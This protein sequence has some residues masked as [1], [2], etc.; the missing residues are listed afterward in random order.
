MAMTNCLERSGLG[1]QLEKGRTPLLFSISALQTICLFDD[2]VA[3][4]ILDIFD[5]DR[6]CPYRVGLLAQQGFS[7]ARNPLGYDREAGRGFQECSVF[8]VLEDRHKF[9]ESLELLVV[10][11]ILARRN[12]A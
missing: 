3:E 12:I 2:L 11:G 8:D 1:H 6:L 5:E 10:G 4:Q 7:R 9:C